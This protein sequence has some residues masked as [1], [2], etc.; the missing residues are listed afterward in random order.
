MIIENNQKKFSQGCGAGF[1][2]GECIF[3]KSSYLGGE[4]DHI[5]K[6]PGDVGA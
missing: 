1:C 5:K 2:P 3:A 6:I 4:F